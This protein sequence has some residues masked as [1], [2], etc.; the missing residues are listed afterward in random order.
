MMVKM[1]GHTLSTLDRPGIGPPPPDPLEITTSSV[2]GA[3]LNAAYSQ[4]VV[5]TGG[6]GG[7]N[8]TVSV[9]ALPT[10]LSLNASNGEITGTPTI[11]ETQNFTV[12][13]EDDATSFDTVALS[14]AVA[15]AM[16]LSANLLMHHEFP[17]AQADPMAAVSPTTI[18]MDLD[19]TNTP[20]WTGSALNDTA[21]VFDSTA[22]AIE[23][24]V[25]A[26]DAPLLLTGAEA[27][28]ICVAI[29][30]ASTSSGSNR[31]VHKSATNNNDISYGV[32]LVSGKVQFGIG[33]RLIKT[34]GTSTAIM[35]ETVDLVSDGLWHTLV[36]TYDGSKTLAGL[37]IYKDG[38][39]QS[40]TTIYDAW[41]DGVA[42]TAVSYRLGVSSPAFVGSIAYHLFW[43]A[44]LTATHAVQLNTY[45]RSVKTT[46]FGGIL[47]SGLVAHYRLD[48]GSGQVIND[49]AGTNHGQLG[50]T[51]GVDAVDPAWQAFG[52]EYTLG[53][54][55]T[56]PHFLSP[57]DGD[58][59]IQIACRVNSSAAQQILLAQQDGVGTGRTWIG[60]DSSERF[61]SFLGGVTSTHTTTM[62]DE[63]EHMGSMVYSGGANVALYQDLG[64]VQN[65]T[66]RTAENATGQ[67]ILGAAKDLGTGWTR[68]I[69]YAL[70]YN[71]ALAAW[72][73]AHN[74]S[75][76][77]AVLAGRSITLP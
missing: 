29:R 14:I 77:K 19:A 61:T 30:T 26:E 69:Y 75:A 72:E 27:F 66:P 31:I 46:L 65:F 58:F 25:G 53:D 13:V 41:A 2:P 52:L 63:T 16:P 5:A 59:S 42:Q 35:I 74:Y 38:V 28:S 73:V 54:Y 10:G 15:F 57:T 3:T 56:I 8:W 1:P 24:P 7:N 18:T 76:I 39:L 47:T 44:T 49:H 20:T 37:K 71:R 62:S 43:T 50:S 21:M 68:N 22:V 67:L 55:F 45:I 36:C 48:E 23:T 70:I 9:G 6:V 12:R 40:V 64:V 33:G 32:Y 11:V 60:I 34:S 17:A 51:S 4:S